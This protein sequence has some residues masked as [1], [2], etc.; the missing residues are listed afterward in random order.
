MCQQMLF[1]KFVPDCVRSNLG[2]SKFKIP[3]GGGKC[4]HTPLVATHAYARY[5]HPATIVFPPNSKS[6]MKP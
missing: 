3:R 6:C 4:P 5:Y 1:E 2:G